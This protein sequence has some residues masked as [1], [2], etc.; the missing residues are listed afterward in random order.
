[1]L[2]DSVVPKMCELCGREIFTSITNVH[3]MLFMFVAHLAQYFYIILVFVSSI[4][5][6][7]VLVSNIEMPTYYTFIF[8]LDH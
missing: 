7:A 2:K 4:Y 5:A 8:V 1:M 3:V 6:E